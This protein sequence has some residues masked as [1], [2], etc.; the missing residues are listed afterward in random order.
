M[1]SADG[2]NELDKTEEM[3][4]AM[5]R[6]RSQFRDPLKESKERLE[7]V[8]EEWIIKSNQSLNNEHAKF[9]KTSV[10]EADL[11]T[12]TLIKTSGHASGC[13]SD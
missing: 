9:N 13:T 8:K 5:Y 10:S 11:T 7:K 1:S 4:D 12:S 3:L 6:Q 2:V